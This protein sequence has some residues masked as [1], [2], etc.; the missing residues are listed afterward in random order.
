M[1]SLERLSATRA[2]WIRLRR[3][4]RARR[5]AISQVRIIAGAWKGR[6]LRV[7]AGVRPTPDRARETVFNWLAP[8]LAGAE[9]LDL[10]AGTGALAFEALSR[11]AAN[12]TL[13]E[14]NAAALRL[15]ARHRDVLGA[16]ATIVRADA[17]RWLDAPSEARWNV[18]FLDPPF[19]EA[20]WPKLLPRLT[21]RLA[22]AGIVYVE[23]DARF[24]LAEAAALS[25]LTVDRSASA[26][27]VRYGLLRAGPRE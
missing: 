14:R 7:A 25:G 2:A 3:G 26:G 12:A 20:P 8:E 5:G 21:P 16:S 13:V 1:G 27:A 23:T 10:F 17:L 6:R 11:G 24:S 22:P 15:L 18:A 19:N 9:V 4:W